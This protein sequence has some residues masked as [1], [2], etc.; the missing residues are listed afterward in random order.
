ML[1][2]LLLLLLDLVLSS[3]FGT[4]ISWCWYLF[5]CAYHHI[6]FPCFAVL[7]FNFNCQRISVICWLVYSDRSIMSTISTTISTT[8]PIPTITSYT[9]LGPIPTTITFPPNCQTDVFDFNADGI[10]VPYT[11]YTQGCALSS[12][13]PSSHVYSTAFE[14]YSNYYSP[15][16]CPSG[17]TSGPAD[18]IISTQSG[19]TVK[20][21]C[22]TFVPSQSPCPPEP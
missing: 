4:R 17:Y 2:L 15:A 21:C 13:C 8:Y 9:N 10:G 1:L 5:L 14:W 16:V 20:W 3:T 19:E 7:F 11:Y 6:F 22:P 12:C 18:P